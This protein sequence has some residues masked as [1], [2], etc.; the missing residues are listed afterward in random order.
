MQHR[1]IDYAVK[2]NFDHWIW[3]VHTP[4]PMTGKAK[5]QIRAMLRA[6]SAIDK[7]CKEHPMLCA[8]HAAQPIDLGLTDPGGRLN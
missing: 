3:I 6:K 2:R 4:Q 8:P 5:N 7:W 1:G